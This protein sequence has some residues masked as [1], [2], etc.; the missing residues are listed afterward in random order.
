M[1]GLHAALDRSADAHLGEVEA[2]AAIP[3]PSFQEHDRAVYVAQRFREAGLSAV[4]IDEADNVRGTLQDG[5]SRPHVILAAHMDTVYP[6]EAHEPPRR[7]GTKLLGSS[8]RDNSPGV[9]A[10]ITLANAFRAAGHPAAGRL[11]FVATTGEEGLGDLRGMRHR[12]RPEE[13]RPDVVLVVDGSLGQI[14]HQGIAVRRFAVRYETDGGHSWGDFGAPNAIHEIAS[15]VH[16]LAQTPIPSDPKTTLNVG[17]IHG[18]TSV[19][20]IAARAEI[21]IDFRSVEGR[22]VDDLT[23]RLGALTQLVEERG[24][25]VTTTII[26][27]RPG[28]WIPPNH[29]LVAAVRDAHRAHGIEPR[30]AAASTDANIPLALGIPAISMGVS[31]GGHVHSPREW[32]DTATLVRGLHLLADVVSH[33]VKVARP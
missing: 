15:L 1:A 14:I 28:G 3:A 7:S 19:N 4:V 18:G 33:V 20:T 23:A 31:G 29:P 17:G 6:R 9:A 27:D 10:L 21:Q 2:I 24:V 22:C 5:A 11:E 13:V 32:L 12:L 8:V 25:R 30:L 26:G 16:A